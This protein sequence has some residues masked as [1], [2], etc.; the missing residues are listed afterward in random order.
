VWK[1]C[2]KEISTVGR[3][4]LK[5]IDKSTEESITVIHSRTD[6]RRHYTSPS[7]ESDQAMAFRRRFFA[8]A[9]LGTLNLAVVEASTSTTGRRSLDLTYQHGLD[10]DT[11]AKS[12]EEAQSPNVDISH[13]MLGDEVSYKLFKKSLDACDDLESFASAANG[14]THRT[15]TRILERLLTASLQKLDLSWNNLEIHGSA[16]K[17]FH[18]A[19]LELLQSPSGCPTTLILDRCSLGPADCRAMG[20]GII[21]R[22]SED[23]N[24]T[25]SCISLSLC[26]NPAMGDSGMAAIAATLRSTANHPVLDRLDLSG[27]NIGDAGAEALA[28]AIDSWQCCV[29][30]HLDLSNNKISHRGAESLARSLGDARRRMKDSIVMESLDLSNNPVGDLGMEALSLHAFRAVPSLT[31]RSCGIQADGAACVGDGLRELLNA[32]ERP[33]F[34]IDLSGNPFGILRAKLKSGGKA[35]RLKSKA[36]ETAASYVNQGIGFIKKG[37]KDVG[38]D[39]GAAEDSDDED[40]FGPG[41]TILEGEVDASKVRCGARALHGAFTNIEHDARTEDSKLKEVWVGLRHCHFDHTAAESLASLKLFA[42]EK[43]G[44]S[45]T[46]DVGLNEVLEEDSIE[47]LHDQDMDRLEEMSEAYMDKIRIIESSKR[48]RNRAP[49]LIEEEM[50]DEDDWSAPVMDGDQWDS[51]ADYEDDYL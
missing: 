41:N 8:I 47:A 46:L 17:L 26:G 28:M 34:S 21:Q 2:A 38:V 31:L 15:A 14:L 18:E 5:K 7:S 29:V 23:R 43:L 48:R 9:V 16:A 1:R 50:E 42:K 27:C 10:V 40:G 19:L 3:G 6:I 51:D 30:K 37:L 32:A 12:I 35:S 24:A 4:R 45:V 39:I 20:K 36:S 44:L 22:F 13:S 33:N 49:S 11:L 25:A